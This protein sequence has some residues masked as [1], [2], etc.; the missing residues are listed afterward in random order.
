MKS[1]R[2]IGGLAASVAAFVLALPL[3]VS[4]ERFRP[5]I[6]AQ[7]Q[8]AMGRP[9]DF[10]ALSL[11]VIPLSLRATGLDIKG[12]AT[13]EVLD[14]KVRFFPLLQGNVE[15]DSLVLTRPVVSSANPAARR[16]R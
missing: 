4:G 3:I 7:L 15:V 16:P 6:K 1:V 11:R 12:L 5:L 14:V 9:V 10:G 13:V 8:S 2:L